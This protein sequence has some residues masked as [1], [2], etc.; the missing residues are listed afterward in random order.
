MITEAI[1]EGWITDLSELNKLKPL[2]DDKG[3]R[4]GFRKAKREAKSQFAAWL[5]S[6]FGQTV[7][8]GLDL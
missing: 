1:G 5:K 7:D 8:P 6:K 2:A 4:D 3:F